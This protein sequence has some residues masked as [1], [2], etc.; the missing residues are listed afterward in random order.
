MSQVGLNLWSYRGHFWDS[1]PVPRSSWGTGISGF[2]SR[3]LVTSNTLGR[4]AARGLEKVLKYDPG[5]SANMKE[6]K[7]GLEQT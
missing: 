2:L 3:V 5:E 7:F 6:T 1:W 4:M